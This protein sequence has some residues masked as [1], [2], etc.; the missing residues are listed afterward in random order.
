MRKRALE[1][2]ARIRHL[3]LS[4]TRLPNEEELLCPILSDCLDCFGPLMPSLQR[5]D[6]T[7]D[8]KVTRGFRIDCL[9]PTLSSVLKVLKIDGYGLEEDKPTLPMLDLARARGCDLEVFICN[10]TTINHAVEALASF[11]TL[12]E[13]E[14][15]P[16]LQDDSHQGS[17]TIVEFLASLPSLRSLTCDLSVFLRCTSKDILHHTSLQKINIDSRPMLFW[18]L[19]HTCTFPSV[20]EARFHYCYSTSR[21]NQLLD[22]NPTHHLAFQ[23]LDTS[24]PNI[25]KLKVEISDQTFDVLDFKHIGPLLALPMQAF[26]LNAPNV[27]LTPSDFQLISQSWPG[28]HSFKICTRKN[29]NGALLSLLAFSNQP[30][31]EHLLLDIEPHSLLND[32]TEVPDLIATYA[33]SPTRVTQRN[34]C[35]LYI[36]ERSILDEILIVARA[37]ERLL[38]ELLLLVFPGLEFAPKYSHNSD[39]ET[40]AEFREILL[41]LRKERK[42]S[43]GNNSR[44]EP[45]LLEGAL[46]LSLQG[47]H[48]H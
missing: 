16:F 18:H 12:R 48:L 40:V 15:S 6:L 17:I 7:C 21:W 8:F 25:R 20:T 24:C 26:Y 3:G 38:V 45:S 47:Q 2:L 11:R 30:Y 1:Y 39:D 42:E 9:T 10:I 28:L 14:L 41:E 31:L 35:T 34:P 23:G 32:I 46:S 22:S 37:D 5:L 44:K 19:F 36:S 29:T 4:Q 27:I 33:L 13:V 43:S